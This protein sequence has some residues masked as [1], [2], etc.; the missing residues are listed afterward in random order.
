MSGRLARLRR[1]ESGQTVTEYLMILGILSAIIAALTK[2]IVPA[3]A[4]GVLGL[5]DHMVVFVS[6]PP[7]G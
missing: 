2:M 1:S 6:T 7:P 4:R 5:L 3:M